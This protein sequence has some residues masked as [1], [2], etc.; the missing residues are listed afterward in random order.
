[1]TGFVCANGILPWGPLSANGNERWPISARVWWALLI[2]NYLC[3]YF[4]GPYFELVPDGVSY[5]LLLLITVAGYSLA[6][7]LEARVISIVALLGGSLAP[8]MLLSGSQ[9]P[10][11]YLPFLLL[12]GGC[13]LLLSH[14][15]RWPVLLETTA[16]L[17]IACIE[18]LSFFVELPLQG[19]G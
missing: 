3:A 15:I 12:I 17:H 10:L 2:I 7:K 9:A 14:K 19:Q 8:L 11:M 5:L 6:L 13:S 4:V 18:S 16:I 1:M